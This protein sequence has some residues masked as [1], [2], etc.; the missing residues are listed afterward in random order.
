MRIYA[1]SGLGAD[2]RVF[3]YLNLEHTLVPIDWIAPLKNENLFSYANR[4]S[5]TIDTSEEFALLGV[6]FGGL[7]AIEVA[8]I[9]PPSKL[10]LISTIESYRD[11]RFVYN[12][13]GISSLLKLVP[14]RFF[15]P[16]RRFIIRLFGAV[17]KALLS[18]ILRDT[19]PQFAKW[20]TAQFLGWRNTEY[21]PISNRIHGTND[22]V[23][24]LASSRP[25]GTYLIEGG[26]HFM[27]VDKAPEVSE[28]INKIMNDI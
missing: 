24:P 4:I 27:I 7:V 22:R 1:F 14:K 16:P 9:H 17:N 18:D 10:I 19:D 26:E 3:D 6:S 13:P 11:R 23:I 12:L 25:G 8:K 28:I 2:K 20:A 15:I 5:T 21:L